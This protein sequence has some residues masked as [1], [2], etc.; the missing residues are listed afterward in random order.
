MSKESIITSNKVVRTHL[1]D[2]LKDWKPEDGVKVVEIRT[3]DAQK[4]EY[5]VKVEIDGVTSAPFEFFKKRILAF[6]SAEEKLHDTNRVHL[7]VN[8]EEGTLV[9]IMDENYEKGTCVKGA[10]QL[11]KFLE[12]FKIN[13]DRT[14]KANDLAKLLKTRKIWFTDPNQCGTLVH[15]LL[16]FEGQW[17]TRVSQVDNQRGNTL[18]K[19]ERELKSEVPLKF[20]LTIPPFKG[21]ENK[22]FDVEIC[23]QYDGSDIKFYL[24]SVDLMTIQHEMKVKEIE[25]QVKKFED[26]I[27]IFEV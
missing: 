23:V 25:E 2:A 18:N 9:L 1:A 22:T 20:T 13:S 21:F 5:P 10:I 19:L 14:F 24:E 11:N 12:E 27:C 17:T 7:L 6:E 26:K 3:G 16:H 4:I 15:N 8:K